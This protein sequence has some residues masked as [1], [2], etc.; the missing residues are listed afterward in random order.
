MKDYRSSCAVSYKPPTRTG[1][2]SMPVLQFLWGQPWDELAMNLVHA[3]RPDCIRVLYWGGMETTD[4][5]V[6]RVTVY[7]NKDGTI[8]HMEQECQVGLEGKYRHGYD[9]WVEMR[10]RGLVTDPELLTR[11]K[12]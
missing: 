9:L 1:F 12:C 10:E 3:L 4:G 2:L 7:L 11:P 6:T 5:R 8:R